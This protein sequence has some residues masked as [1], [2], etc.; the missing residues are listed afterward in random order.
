[1]MF[2]RL[3]DKKLYDA[4]LPHTE[5]GTGT[6]VRTDTPLSRRRHR[7]IASPRHPLAYLSTSLFN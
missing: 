4:A 3:N 5:A 2:S 7:M 1:M 6:A